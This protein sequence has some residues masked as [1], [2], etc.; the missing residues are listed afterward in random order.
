MQVACPDEVLHLVVVPDEVKAGFSSGTVK[1][2]HGETDEGFRNLE[3]PAKAGAK[4]CPVAR[5]SR[6]GV[7]PIHK[8]TRFRV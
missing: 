5:A 1:G 8:P 3:I 2:P 7:L 6:F 4:P